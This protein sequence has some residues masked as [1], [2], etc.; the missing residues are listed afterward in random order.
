MT[1]TMTWC[2]DGYE[3]DWIPAPAELCI[4]NREMCKRCG[5]KRTNPFLESP[6]DE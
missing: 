5:R 6:L 1:D 3:H 4:G 2:P